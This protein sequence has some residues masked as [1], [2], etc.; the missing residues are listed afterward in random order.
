MKISITII[1][2]AK[3]SMAEIESEAK[4]AKTSTIAMASIKKWHQRNNGNG[5][6]AAGEKWLSYQAM[7]M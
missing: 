6:M 3:Y 4:A 2:A 1:M 5:V 7:A